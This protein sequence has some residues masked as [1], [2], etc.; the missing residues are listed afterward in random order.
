MS[1]NPHM[2]KLLH[3]ARSKVGMSDETYR[4]MLEGFGAKSS[5]DRCLQPAHYFEM[6]RKF[7]QLGF[8]PAPKPATPAGG[9]RGQIREIERLCRQHQVDEKRFKGILKYVTGRDALKWCDRK[10]LSKLIQALRRWNYGA[11]GTPAGG[12]ES[13]D[14]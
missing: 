12:K 8:V 1:L 4:A 6:M 11:P 10:D 13:A 3:V 5:K 14:G 7:A 2:I 9:S